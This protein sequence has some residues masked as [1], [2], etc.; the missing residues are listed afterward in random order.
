MTSNVPYVPLSICNIIC[1]LEYLPDL[2]YQLSC[3]FCLL[4]LLAF[5]L[6]W[7]WRASTRQKYCMHNTS[8]T[9]IYI[10]LQMCPAG[11]PCRCFGNLFQKDDGWKS[12]KHCPK[13]TP[14]RTLWYLWWE[15][16]QLYSTVISCQQAFVSPYSE[17][18]SDT[19][20]NPFLCT[21]AFC[22]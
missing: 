2:K 21:A 9:S 19:Q 13:Q 10:V 6:D 17:V 4:C 14:K 7:K 18:S 22:S 8:V 16:I 5:Y 1:S 11:V 3:F 12:N 15:S 20:Q